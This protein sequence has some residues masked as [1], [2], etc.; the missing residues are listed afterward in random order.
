LRRLGSVKNGPWSADV[1]GVA[2]A[3][4]DRGP[5]PYGTVLGRLIVA[6]TLILVPIF[7]IT[8][9]G[10]VQLHRSSERFSAVATEAAAD[11]RLVDRLLTELERADGAVDLYLETGEPSYL[12]MYGRAKRT[13]D[14]GFEVAGEVGSTEGREYALAASRRAVTIAARVDGAQDSWESGRPPPRSFG[15]ENELDITAAETLV[16][17]MLEPARIGIEKEVASAHSKRTDDLWQLGLQIG[18]GVLLAAWVVRR[19]ARD[20]VGPLARLSVAAG[21]MGAGHYSDRVPADGPVELARLGAAFNAMGETLEAQQEDLRRLAYSDALTGLPNRSGFLGPMGMNAQ[22]SVQ[23][24]LFLDLDDFKSV[25]DALGQ[26][27][28]DQLLVEVALRIS[29]VLGETGMVARL[30]GD[31]FAVLLPESDDDLREAVTLA[32]RLLAR[33]SEPTIIAGMEL[34]PAASMGIAMGTDGVESLLRDAHMAI[35]LAKAEG[36][37]G[38]AFFEPEMRETAGRRLAGIADLRQAL[39]A[40]Q[41]CV[42]YQPIVELGT[43]TLCATEA[44]VRWEHP[45]RGLVPPGD[46]IPL[47]EETGLIVDIG[48]LV[49][50]EACRQVVAWDAIRPGSALVMTVNLSTRQL[51]ESELV[52]QVRSALADVGLAPGRLMLEITE[53]AVMADPGAAITR[54]A[55]LRAIGVRLAIDDFGTG[56][57]SLAYLRDLP[58]DELKIARE[59]VSG[60]DESPHDQALAQGIL[61]LGHGLGLRVIAEGIE[62]EAQHARLQMMGCDLAQGYLYSR[63][64]GPDDVIGLLTSAMPPDPLP[65]FVATATE[66]EPLPAASPL[67]S[68]SSTVST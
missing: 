6:A 47:A 14:A 55:E 9:F 15:P 10:F 34:V 36:R 63:P 39:E 41:F 12:A 32:D 25:N 61:A 11:M 13:L 60:I 3:S 43:R 5:R 28:G 23:T 42:V 7:A 51:L 26:P 45:E 53:S 56:H 8:I 1:H 20:T 2:R 68:A 65:G 30:G 67:P 44:L 17:R 40:R 64:L 35:Y 18:L 19:L 27:A 21:R 29:E 24:V 52:D 33:L 59:F 58:V 46:F 16:A 48:D 66:A 38:Y 50:R 22:G 57:S 37:H 4:G 62:T 49:L 31:E 54:L